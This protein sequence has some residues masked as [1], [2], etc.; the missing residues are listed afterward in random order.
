MLRSSFSLHA[1]TIGEHFSG[2]QFAC[3][4]LLSKTSVGISEISGQK[5]GRHSL[6]HQPDANAIVK[7]IFL[8]EVFVKFT[9]SRN[10]L[11]RP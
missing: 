2:K 8:R 4:C 6:S 5:L 3:G 11:C 7:L 1:T 9:S 10:S